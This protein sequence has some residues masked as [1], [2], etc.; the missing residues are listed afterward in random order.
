MA[1]HQ[2]NRTFDFNSVRRG[3]IMKQA[4]TFQGKSAPVVAAAIHDGHELRSTVMSHCA[5]AES[6]R[7]REED[8]HTG[9][10]TAVA[11][12][13]V[14]VHRSRFEVDINRPREQAVY[15]SPE[16][17]W[18]LNVWKK[19]LPPEIH[20]GSLAIYDYFY[21]SMQQLLDASLKEFGIF[22]L[23][24]LHSYNHRRGGPGAPPD[25]PTLNPDINIGTRWV[26][27]RR[28]RP[29]IDSFMN[30]LIAGT[31]M[32]HVLHVG[33][34]TKFGGGNLSRWTNGRYA[35]RGLCLAIEFKKIFMDEW[36][37]V[38]NWTVFD[39]LL[40]LL[41]MAVSALVKEMERL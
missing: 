6:D 33:E 37:G 13:R 20:R 27:G 24:D 23:L 39:E 14:I 25:D 19:P 5:L 35:E 3:T 17:A 7:L 11:D 38:V 15:L 18:G 36:T 9:D 40:V 31:V 2:P 29:L 28:F 16:D 12:C 1:V 8:P 4:F 22:V 32:G 26:T 34:N 10:L 41:A 21:R 30:T